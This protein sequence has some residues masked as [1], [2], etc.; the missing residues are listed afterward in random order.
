MGPPPAKPPSSSSSSVSRWWMRHCKSATSSRLPARDCCVAASSCLIDRTRAASGASAETHP[1]WLLLLA[2]ASTELLS[3]HHLATKPRQG[4]SA[5]VK[6]H[7]TQH[8]ARDS[9]K[10]PAASAGLAPGLASSSE[11]RKYMSPATR[12]ENTR[13]QCLTVETHL[14]VHS[15]SGPQQLLLLSPVP[16]CN[17]KSKMARLSKMNC[18]IAEGMV[19][20]RKIPSCIPTRMKACS[21][22]R[23][24]SAHA[25]SSS[26]G[27]LP[28]RSLPHRRSAKVAGKVIQDITS[29]TA[30]RSSLL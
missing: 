12:S 14:A 2:A 8:W 19:T 3:L 1:A 28:Y 7:S 11:E 13:Q 23:T 10:G 6:N 15:Q 18:M 26:L 30:M 29:S 22:L 20:K 5:S 25:L 24:A 4:S 9:R 16:S 21:T 27:C 17:W